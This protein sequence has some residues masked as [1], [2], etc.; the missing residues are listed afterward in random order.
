[1]DR[2]SGFQLKYIGGECTRFP[3]RRR[4]LKVVVPIGTVPMLAA[5]LDDP[6]SL[7]NWSDNLLLRC[8]FAES[9][10]FVSDLYIVSCTHPHHPTPTASTTHDNLHTLTPPLSC[11]FCSNSH[12]VRVRPSSRRTPQ[13]QS[14]VLDHHPSETLFLEFC[15]PTPV[16]YRF[17]T[18][19]RIRSLKPHPNLTLPLSAKRVACEIGCQGFVALGDCFVGREK[20]ETFKKTNEVCYCLGENLEGRNFPSKTP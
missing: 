16:C 9:L 13:T 2:V 8:S 19:F 5:E 11:A 10:N 12:W 1:M 3:T 7:R 4:R 17:G 6:V 20:C 18:G 15:V 14:P